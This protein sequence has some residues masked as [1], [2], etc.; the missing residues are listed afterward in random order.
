LNDFPAQCSRAMKICPVRDQRFLKN[1][2]MES[3]NS[4]KSFSHI[5]QTN[6]ISTPK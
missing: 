3:F 5:P 4:G 2:P 1:D 6:E